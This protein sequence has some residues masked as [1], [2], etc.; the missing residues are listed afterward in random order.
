MSSVLDGCCLC[1]FV[2]GGLDL[3]SHDR[4]GEACGGLPEESV[5]LVPI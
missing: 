2:S 3:I 4:L 5:V 1:P